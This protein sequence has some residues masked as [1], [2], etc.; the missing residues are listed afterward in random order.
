MDVTNLVSRYVD[1]AR[2]SSGVSKEASAPQSFVDLDLAKLAD[3]CAALAIELAGPGTPIA[4]QVADYISKSAAGGPPVVTETKDTAPA[5]IAPG[6]KVAPKEGVSEVKDTPPVPAAAL[7]ATTKKA[8]I[9]DMVTKRA[10]GALPTQTID[11]KVSP[12]TASTPAGSRALSQAAMGSNTAMS[13]LPRS[14]AE[15]PG[16]AELS[17]YFTNRTTPMAEYFTRKEASAP[18]PN[19]ITAALAARKAAKSGEKKEDEKSEKSE[20]KGED[21]KDGEKKSGLPRFW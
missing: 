19:S 8:S 3:G 1:R 18:P 17:T 20:K 15:A 2:V 6:K 7:I 16:N 10:G 14:K 12:P 9:W 11:Q 4:R 5:T 21:K 13:T